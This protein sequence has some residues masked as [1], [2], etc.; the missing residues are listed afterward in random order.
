MARGRHDRFSPAVAAGVIALVL[1]GGGAT[2]AVYLARLGAERGR[3]SPAPG[4]GA[5]PAQE[6]A[7]PTLDAP[8]HGSDLHIGGRSVA[9]WTRRLN[10]LKGRGDPRVYDLT[11]RRAEDAG[12]V[13]RERGGAIEVSP[14][15]DLVRQAFDKEEP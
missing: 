4:K 10:D 15:T 13:V 5:G 3:P 2:A 9:W 1:L 8:A 14:S 12:L 7:E 11:R 6:G